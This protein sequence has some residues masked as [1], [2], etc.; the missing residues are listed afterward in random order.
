MAENDKQ[1]HRNGTSTS[2]FGSPGRFGHD[3]SEF[4][5]SRLYEDVE[6]DTN[7]TYIENPISRNVTNHIFP[8]SSEVMA[9]LPDSSIHLVVT[10]P[11]Y[12]V[13]KEYDSNLSLTEYRNFLNRIF[14][15]VY[16][17]LV[18]GGRVCL[19]LANLGRSPYIPLHAYIIQDMIKCKYLMRGEIIWDKGSSASRSTA[20]GSWMSPTNPTLRDTH[21]YILI[22]SKQVYTLPLNGRKPTITKEEFLEFTKSIWYFNAESAKK[23]GH[24]APFPI[25]LPYRCIQL[26]TAEDDVILDPF[27]GAGTT[28]LAAQMTKRRFIGYEVEQKYCDIAAKRLEKQAQL[29]LEEVNV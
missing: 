2:A 24:P 22:F 6:L 13:G 27:M 10:S 25:E 12:N 5:A 11:P 20:W 16:R 18:P 9:E 21:E 15:E 23:V 14:T 26:Y 17:V 28:A 7:V 19:N 1:N 29:S 4:Y 8:R 3:S